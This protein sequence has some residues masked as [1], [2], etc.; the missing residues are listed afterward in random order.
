MSPNLCYSNR[1][2]ADYAPHITASARNGDA[3]QFEFMA[4]PDTE[5]EGVWFVRIKSQQT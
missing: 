4:L 2:E 5:C 3:L 1:G